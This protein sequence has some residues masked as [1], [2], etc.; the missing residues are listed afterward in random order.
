VVA[1]NP[2]NLTQQ[3]YQP[4][5]SLNS[6][7]N[8]GLYAGGVWG[9]GGVA[10]AP[11]G[12]VYALTGNATQLGSV[13]SDPQGNNPQDGLESFGDYWGTVSAL[14]PG[15][16]GDY[17]NALV[18]LEI[19]GTGS[20]SQIQVRDWF[21]GASFTQQENG[22]DFDFGGS[23]P[24]VL[25][26]IDGQ[27]LVAFVPKDGD[28]FV[29]DSQQ[30]GNYTTPLTRQTFADALNQNG[31]DTKVA[32]AFL[33]TPDQRNILVVGADS[34]GPSLGG[35]AAFELDAS[36]TPPT[37]A[38]LWQA[39]SLLRD[40]F[41]SPTII[42]NPVP[43]PS[44]PLDPIA[45]VWVIDG[46]SPNNSNYCDNCAM[47]AYDV[48]SGTI[49]YDSTLQGDVTEQIPHFAPITSGGN[50]V[51]CG[52]ST[53]FIGFTQFVEVPRSLSF[54]VERSTYGKDEIDADEPTPTSVATINPAYWV[55]VNG[56]LPSDLGLTAGNLNAPPQL[57][58][59]TTSFEPL[60]ASITTAIKNML[61]ASAFSA[62]VVPE[63]PSL[64]DQPQG[65]LFP[66]E[67]TFTG[68]QGFQAMAGASPAISSTLVTLKG[69]MTVGGAALPQSSVQIELVTGEDPFFENIN[70]DPQDT[71]L[72]P[73]WLSYDLRFLKMTVPASGPNPTLFGV[74][75]TASPADAPGFIASV[76]PKMT[77]D[78]FDNTLTQ[79]EDTSGS[80]RRT[81]A[82]T[83]CSTLR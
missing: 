68:D 72:F 7:T 12:T 60:P 63:I 39:P 36:A 61:N 66:F 82:A 51:F 15:N 32:I 6:S 55:V 56:V 30:L 40:S 22:A 65:F 49:A 3:L 35:F 28:V 23:S 11:D 46:D 37:L 58:T 25:P 14:G 27:Q 53:G 77:N 81:T 26:E 33:Q 67:V 50:S 21:Q 41:G 76:L 19:T 16:L 29:L 1:I 44:N 71:T 47:R 2:D 13:A 64:P 83:R 4:M 48:V 78:Y 69:S 24:V 52:T 57:P 9:P 20:T 70:P 10:A 17:F 62:P 79:V 54:I 45:L 73:T 34:N 75:M 43:D 5:I 31:N 42:A 59:V 18:R 80:T 74:T 8:L 38:K